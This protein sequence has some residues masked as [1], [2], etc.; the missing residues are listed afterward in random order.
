MF[1]AAARFRRFARAVTAEVGALD[2]SYLGLG[3]PLG[4]A[5]VLNAVGEG[6]DDIAE[7]RARLR[8]DSGLMSRLLRGLEDE[9]LVRTV[10]APGD[11]RRRLVQLSEQGKREYDAYE[12]IANA[13]ARDFLERHHRS[14]ELLAALDMVA[15]AFLHD[16]IEIASVSP[17]DPAAKY[18]LALYYH[19]L[20]ATFE[21]GFDLAKSLDPTPG[22]MIA[23]NGAFVIAT[24]DK[25]PVGCVG[26]RGDGGDVGEVKRLWVAPAARGLGISY[27]L[28]E[29]VESA[30]RSLGMLTLRLGTNRTLPGAIHLYRRLGWEE[31]GPYSADPYSHYFFRKT[32]AD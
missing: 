19:E 17:T 18:C 23:P 13:R 27:R 26:L 11:G 32:L 15:S 12:N 5:R 9:G 14:D 2:T 25:L 24:S 31:T 28:M 3:R 4:A 1:D 29:A 6:A 20:E 30:A 21:G 10:P 16:Q 8:L 7:I 22:Q